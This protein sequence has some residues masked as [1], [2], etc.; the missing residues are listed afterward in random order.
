MG[1]ADSRP[2]ESTSYGLVKSETCPTEVSLWK[3]KPIVPPPPLWAMTAF[4]CVGT[5]FAADAVLAEAVE[6]VAVDLFP[7]MVETTAP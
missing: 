3:A 6:P 2:C 1:Y 7:L 4:G 5:S